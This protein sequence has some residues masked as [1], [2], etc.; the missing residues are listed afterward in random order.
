MTVVE[1]H[2]TFPVG[3]G[4]GSRGSSELS[5]GRLG[6]LPGPGVAWPSSWGISWPRARGE[7]HPSLPGALC[8]TAPV[9][10]KQPGMIFSP[11]F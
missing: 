3:L 8:F 4:L 11:L 6:Q 7:A 1:G 5:P 9:P 10:L 2:K